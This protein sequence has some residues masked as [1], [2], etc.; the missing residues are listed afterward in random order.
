MRCGTELVDEAAFC[1]KCGCATGTTGQVVFRGGGSGIGQK[2]I[3]GL[4][5]LVMG[6]MGFIYSFEKRIIGILIASGIVAVVGFI[7][8]VDWKKHWRERK[9]ARIVILVYV[10]LN[11]VG[12][13][14]MTLLAIILR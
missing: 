12:V 5:M 1:T 9:V 14:I 10:L 7:L 8:M 2:F 3:G 6:V 11:I 13:V 4:V